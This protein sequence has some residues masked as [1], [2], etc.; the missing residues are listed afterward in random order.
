MTQGVETGLISVPSLQNRAGDFAGRRKL[1]N[2][3]R[4]RPVLGRSAFKQAWVM[5]FVPGEPYYSAG[6][7]TTAQCVFPNAQ[8]PRRAW[9][10]P[11]E[12]LLP[13]IPVPN[14]GEHDLLHI[15]LQSEPARR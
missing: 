10:A 8:I 2:R 4:E 3:H 7:V 15:G 13:S 6:C 1:F 12:A 11:A 9:S 14:Q 5:R